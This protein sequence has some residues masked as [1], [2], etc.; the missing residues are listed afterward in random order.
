MTEISPS[1]PHGAIAQCADWIDHSAGELQTGH[2]RHQ[3]TGYEQYYREKNRT[4][5]RRVGL[6]FRQL[7]ERQPT[8]RPNRCIRSEHGMT[9]NIFSIGGLERRRT[10]VAARYPDLSE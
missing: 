1:D 5:E 10:E 2:H 4:V 8:E 3:K 7:Y 9:V 6:A